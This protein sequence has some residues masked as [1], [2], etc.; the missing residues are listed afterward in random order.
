MSFDKLASLNIWIKWVEV[1]SYAARLRKK[2][3]L[4]SE[5][6]KGH[7]SPILTT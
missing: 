7:T 4:I 3:G 6:D 1:F 2:M 5:E